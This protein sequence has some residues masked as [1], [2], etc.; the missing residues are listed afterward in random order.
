M[1]SST[2]NESNKVNYS[3]LVKG[4]PPEGKT[5]AVVAVMKRAGG[6]HQTL[7]KLD[8]Q[9]GDGLAVGSRCRLVNMLESSVGLI[10]VPR[11]QLPKNG[12]ADLLI[13]KLQYLAVDVV[14]D[15]GGIDVGFQ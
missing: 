15:L 4:N 1:T 5:T 8:H 11:A 10:A 9:Q 13:A 2:Q 7:I 6:G 14:P 3:T 12:M